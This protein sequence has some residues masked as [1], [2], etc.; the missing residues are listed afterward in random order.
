MEKNSYNLLIKAIIKQST[1]EGAK[2][3]LSDLC[4]PQELQ[5]MSERI[6]VAYLLSQGN[7]SYRKIQ[8][9]TGVSL[10]TITRVARFLKDEKYGGY[11]K[12]FEELD[13]DEF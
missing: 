12:F 13:K 5:S 1:E 10:S 4:T 6:F 9:E 8:L 2:N 11:R 3:F 7:K